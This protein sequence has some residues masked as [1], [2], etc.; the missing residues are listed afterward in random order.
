MKQFH[1]LIFLKD[2]SIEDAIYYTYGNYYDEDETTPAHAYDENIELSLC[3]QLGTET[4][5]N[6]FLHYGWHGYQDES[7]WELNHNI[8]FDAT[9]LTFIIAESKSLFFVQGERRRIVV[10]HFPQFNVDNPSDLERPIYHSMLNSQKQMGYIKALP[11]HP[12][13]PFFG[14]SFFN[15]GFF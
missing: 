1:N 5:V 8:P 12:G 13:R 6:Y 10:T 11:Y 4:S 7:P 15:S 9:K 14:I 2:P 3:A